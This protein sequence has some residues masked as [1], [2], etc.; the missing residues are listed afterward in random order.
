MQ[1]YFDANTRYR[2]GDERALYERL[3][4]HSRFCVE[5]PSGKRADGLMLR[6]AT[7]AGGLVVSR[8]KYR[9]FRKRYRRLIDDPARLLAGSAGGGRLR[10]PG[11]GVDLPLPVSAEAAWA[12]LEASLLTLT[13]AAQ[14][15]RAGPGPRW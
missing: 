3:L 15:S 5:V 7:A 9:D 10:V 2:L 13:Q 1:L 11:L 12:G 8:D 4:E 14:A 6:A